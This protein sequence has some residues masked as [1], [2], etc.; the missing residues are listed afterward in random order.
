VDK[1]LVR[2]KKTVPVSD[3]VEMLAVDVLG[4]IPH[5]EKASVNATEVITYDKRCRAGMA[6]SNIVR[7][8]EGESVSLT[9]L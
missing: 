2:S 6:Y 4:I 8:L 5:D 3:I 9:K 7:R 1:K